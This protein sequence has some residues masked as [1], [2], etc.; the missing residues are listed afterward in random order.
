[1]RKKRKGKKEREKKTE[2]KCCGTEIKFILKKLTNEK[3]SNY[4]LI[5]KTCFVS[6]LFLLTFHIVPTI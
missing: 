2:F 5:K 4:L 1:M 6:V 3:K